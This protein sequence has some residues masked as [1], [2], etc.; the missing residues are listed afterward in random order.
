M[1]VLWLSSSQKNYVHFIRDA[2]LDIREAGHRLSLRCGIMQ[3]GELGPKF[4]AHLYTT[5]LCGVGNPSGLLNT[6]NDHTERLKKQQWDQA[7]C[8]GTWKMYT[9]Q[10][11]VSY[12]SFFSASGRIGL[13]CSPC[14]P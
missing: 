9:V 5:C 3:S 10:N 7:E 14:H 12:Q 2:L 1:P 11:Y 4:V 13:C 8:S 6:A